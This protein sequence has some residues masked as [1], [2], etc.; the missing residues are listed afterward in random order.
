MAQQGQLLRIWIKRAH[1][2]PMDPVDTARLQS[3]GGVVDNADWGAKRHVTLLDDA[4]W[5]RAERDLGLAVDPASRRAN[6]L[7]SGIPLVETA[8]RTLRIGPARLIIRGE[9]RP[10]EILDEAQ[11]GLKDALD[12]DWGGGAWAEVIEDGDIHVGDEVSWEDD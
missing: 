6:L 1:K 9:T 10:C 4:R 2:A 3:D 5:Q 8:G 12:A 7:L 11:P